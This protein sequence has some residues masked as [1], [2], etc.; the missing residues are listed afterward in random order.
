M[1][2]WQ[3]TGIF[4]KVSRNKIPLCQVSRI[5]HIPFETHG[6]RAKKTHPVLTNLLRFI[7]IM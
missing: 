1:G 5:W 6:P 2:T 3:V 7:A 4:L